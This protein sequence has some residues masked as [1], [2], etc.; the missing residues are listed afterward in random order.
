M[1]ERAA[2]RNPSPTARTLNNDSLEQE[3][4]ETSELLH[5]IFDA[6]PFA[7]QVVGSDMNVMMWNAAA[8]KLFGYESG[9]VIGKSML[10][11]VPD[12]FKDSVREGFNEIA[13]GAPTRRLLRPVRHRDG[14]VREAYVSAAP[15]FLPDGRIRA[16]AVTFEDVTDQRRTEAQLRQSQKMEAIGNLTGGLAHDFNNLLAIIIGNLDLAK[17]LLKPK[18]DTAELT[19]LVDESVSAALRGAELTQRLLAFARR[20]PLSPSRLSMNELVAGMVK[21]LERTLGENITIALDLVPDLWPVDADAS[22]LEAAIVNLATNARDA[23][24]KGGKLTIATRNRRVDEEAAETYPGLL[25]GD[26]AVIEVSDTGSGMTQAV[27]AHIFDPFFTTKEAGKGTG[28]GLSMVFGFLKQSGGHIGVYSEVGIGTTFRLYL[29][30]TLNLDM[31]AASQRRDAAVAAGETVLAVED[32]DGLRR[33]V[34]R[35]LR[36]LGYRVVETESAAAA[37][38]FLEKESVDL[39][40][41]DVVMPGEIDGFMLAKTVLH[42]YPAI[43]VVLT[44]GFPDTKL[45]G[46]LSALTDHVR[47]LSKPYRKDDLAH[48]LREVLER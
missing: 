34:V 45:N 16:V 15:V 22:Q 32:N 9:D 29:P 44:S 6:A 5:A 35:Q 10:L 19:E 3:L 11:T 24:P 47:L 30:R 17:M 7:I 8:E 2:L 27:T 41:T 4:R 40:F 36:D 42:Q 28:L 13:N 39:V 37:L 23:M 33:V 48:L 31:D 18:S 21:L 20:Q 14:R 46:A 38:A 25:P 43:K 26:Y 12:D 1:Q